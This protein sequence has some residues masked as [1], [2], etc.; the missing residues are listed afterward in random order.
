MSKRVIASAAGRRHIAL[1]MS[2]VFAST[3]LLGLATTTP[4][5]AQTSPGDGVV[6]EQPVVVSENALRSDSAGE[7][8]IAWDPNTAAPLGAWDELSRTAANFHLS[9]GGSEGYGSIFALRGLA[10]TPYFSDPS[11]TV[12]FADIPLPSSSTYPTNLMGF[13]SVSLYRGPEGTQFGRATDGGVV[14]FSPTTAANELT[15]SFGSYDD[16]QVAVSE[17]VA[18]HGVS[19]T[20]LAGYNARDGYITNQQIG[21]K[22]DQQ[23]NENFYLQSAAQLAPAAKVTVELM[24]DRARDGAEPLVPLTGPKF[25]VSRPKE[26]VTDLDSWGA[27]LRGDFT[28][29]E[30]SRLSSVTSFTDWRM[31]PY[32]NSLVT[33][34]RLDSSI[35]QDQKSWNEELHWDSDPHSVV[36]TKLGVWLSRTSTDNYVNR[37]VFVPIQLPYEV[38]SFVEDSRQAA[39]FGD[40]VIALTPSLKLTTGMRA[41]STERG[42]TRNERAPNPGFGYVGSN[43]YSGFLPKVA[44]AWGMKPGGY[45]SYTDNPKLISFAAER[46]AS[47]TAGWD[48][49]FLQRQFELAVRG[50]Y[51]RVGNYQIERSFDASGDYYVV[52]APQAGL[53]G[54]EVEAKW[55]PGREWTV[56]LT[57]GVTKAELLTYIN[58]TTG[59]S[60]AGNTVPYVPKYN[61]SLEATWRPGRGFFA[62]AQ[63][64]AVGDTY[65]DELET[66]AYEQHSY[67]ILGARAGYETGR[68]SVTVYG[69]NLTNRGYFDLIVPGVG[70]GAPGAPRRGGVELGLKW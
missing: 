65:F 54:G 24:G 59:L 63:A 23:E 27:A 25:D 56:A 29:P 20:V 13:S 5:W 61:G 16:R 45:A 66:A 3:L 34:V 62:G 53:G 17:T 36:Q 32:S 49:A 60:A 42:L 4:L 38:S 41:E 8:Q 6:K 39:L 7:T 22:V 9:D 15:A 19:T 35:L 55:H 28:L 64:A 57:G 18:D 43:R 52:N 51:T 26:G 69:E 70:S 31:N 2:R 21:Q 30:N 48:K 58:P 44:L 33:G 40:V 68:W 14:T 67:A 12:Y 37:S 46:A 47:V 10:N 1:S 50:F 11:V